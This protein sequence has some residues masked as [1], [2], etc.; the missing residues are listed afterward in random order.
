MN[1][2]ST[3][4]LTHQSFK[5]G[6]M[7]LVG[8]LVLARLG[9]SFP[10]DNKAERIQLEGTIVLEAIKPAFPNEKEKIQ[11]GTPVKVSVKIE[12][13]GKLTSFP[14]DVYVC[15]ALAKPLH[16]EEGSVIFES[17][18]VSLAPIEPG[19]EIMI[20]FDK[21]HQLPGLLDFVR[22]DWALREYQV[23]VQMGQETQLIGTLALTFSA[24]YYPGVLKQFNAEFKGK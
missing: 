18:K 19:K 11:P 1:K 22:D 17:D 6:L 5:I 8:I 10:A 12:N 23:Y 2:G 21:L 20:T 7:L 14:G 13:K 15:Y 9:Y 24:Y 3:S 16:T 4:F